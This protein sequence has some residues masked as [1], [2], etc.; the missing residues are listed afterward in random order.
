MRVSRDQNATDKFPLNLNFRPC[1]V[2]MKKQFCITK[3]LEAAT[4]WFVQEWGQFGFLSNRR[5]MLTSNSSTSEL[6]IRRQPATVVSVLSSSKLSFWQRCRVTWYRILDT[7][8]K[9]LKF[10]A[11]KIRIG[12]V[13]LKLFETGW[14]Y[15][16]QET[17]VIRDINELQILTGP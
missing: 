15:S 2:R 16:K 12:D 13:I 7:C 4:S 11:A 10:L 1:F 17:P 8:K 5:K 14:S 6:S 3:V 9:R